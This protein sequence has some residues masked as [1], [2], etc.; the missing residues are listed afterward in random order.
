MIYITQLIYI[1]KG[2]EKVFHEFGHDIFE[3]EHSDGIR[4]MTTNKLDI[5]NPSVL[6]EMIHEMFIAVLKKQKEK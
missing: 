6:G 3:L 2:Q 5:K 1:K 4:L